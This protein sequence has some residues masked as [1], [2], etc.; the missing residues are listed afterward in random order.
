MK[1]KKNP[2]GEWWIDN[3]GLAIYADGDVSDTNH[4]IEAFKGAIGL[5]YDLLE[6]YGEHVNANGIDTSA[7]GEIYAEEEGIETTDQTNM[8]EL[9]YKWLHEHGANMDFV[10]HI[11]S[12]Q[13][14][15][16]WQIQHD[17]WVR[18]QGNNFQLWQFDDETLGRIVSSD[19]WDNDIS[20]DDDEPL[21]ESQDEVY[22]EEMGI[23]KVHTVMLKD[24]FRA[25]V[26]A[27]ELKLRSA[28]QEWDEIQ[29]KKVAVLP[30]HT[31]DKAE[32]GK[33][34]YRRRGDN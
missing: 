3:D 13:D 26:T 25:G 29:P 14:S 9:G 34:L 31:T 5:D 17:G 7:L 8:D 22:I 19:I 32:G 27:N 24:L 28:G 33:W 18:V 21:E 2:S 30:K 12:G 6:E 11:Q 16:L 4:E 23:Q 15:R 1:R 10:A 20:T